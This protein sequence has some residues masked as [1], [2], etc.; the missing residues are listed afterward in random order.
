MMQ[1]ASATLD[2]SLSLGAERIK[3][4]IGKKKVN[5]EKQETEVNNKELLYTGFLLLEKNQF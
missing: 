1:C 5:F 2:S 4:G 3:G